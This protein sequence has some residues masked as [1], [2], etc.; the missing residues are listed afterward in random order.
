MVNHSVATGYIQ[1]HFHNR[2]AACG[3]KRG[4]NVVVFYCAR[5]HYHAVKNFA[6]HVERRNEVGPTIA[7]EQAHFFAHFGFERVIACNRANVSVKDNVI[8]VFINRFFHVKRLQALCAVFAFGV[9][10]ALHHIELFVHFGQAFF[11]FNQNQAIHTVGDMHAHRRS[12]AVVNIQTRL[13]C[14]KAEYAGMTR[15]SERSRR[16]AA[17]AGCGV[18]VNIVRHSGIRAV[19]EMH[20]HLVA[21]AHADKRTGHIAVE[22][23]V[24]VVHAVC[25][26]HYF[27]L[28]FDVHFHASCVVAVDSRGNFGCFG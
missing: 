2:R 10:I 17:R 1:F 28:H 22:R 25:H 23:P 15:G 16:A 5:F 13:Q 6:N 26:F 24:F 14:F 20:F 19:G 7:H 11:G 27:F 12:R 8:C 3:N 18:E 4:L 21:F 9:E